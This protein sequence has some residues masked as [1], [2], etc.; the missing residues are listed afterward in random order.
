MR[1][2]TLDIGVGGILCNICAGSLEA[3]LGHV[4]SVTHVSVNLATERPRLPM[5]PTH[6]D[7]TTN[8]LTLWALT[9]VASM[10]RADWYT[11]PNGRSKH[12]L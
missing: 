9:S 12:T 1:H 4:P 11:W 2:V 6:A 8:H 10:G 7:V 3:A 5:M